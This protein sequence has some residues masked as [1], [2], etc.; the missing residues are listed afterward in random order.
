MTSFEYILII[1]PAISITVSIFYN[2]NKT[3]IDNIFSVMLGYMLL[4]EIAAIVLVKFH[5]LRYDYIIFNLYFLILPLIMFMMFHKLTNSVKLKT[6]IRNLATILVLFFITDNIVLKNILFELQF[7]TY[8][9]ALLFL[10]YLTYVHLFEIL[11]AEKIKD[12]FRSKSALI[13]IGILIYSIPYMPIVIA[14][15]A[16]NIIFEVRWILAFPLYTLMHFC[17]IIASIWTRHK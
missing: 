1:F 4:T 14:F 5:I 12:Y 3:P 9:L 8:L 10:C 15:N 6:R 13:S 11:E 2:F 7:H 17:F 16:I